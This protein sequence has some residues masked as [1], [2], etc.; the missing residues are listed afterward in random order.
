MLLHLHQTGR[1]KLQMKPICSAVALF[2]KLPVPGKVK[3]RLAT[4]IGAEK[5]C[6]IYHQLASTAI[7]Q[8]V[9]SGY[10]LVLFFDG[11]DPDGLPEDWRCLANDCLPQQGSDLGERMSAA[12][13]RLFAEGN[14]QVVLIGSDI[15]GL[16]A[17]Y[18]KT[19]FNALQQHDVVIGP[20]EDGGYC[21]IGF[22][23]STFSP[24][25]FRGILWS[26]EFVF[27]QT[28]HACTQLNLDVFSLPALRDIDTVDDL[29]AVSLS[30]AT[31]V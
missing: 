10:P 1:H 16:D 21:L 15:P 20:A 19:A 12:F 27:E 18:L 14:Q 9:I 23:S 3:T 8:A 7:Q 24:Q 26:T 25:L 2:V 5:A 29:H 31:V 22:H 11:V 28:C 13:N 30:I 17:D 4:E 6:L